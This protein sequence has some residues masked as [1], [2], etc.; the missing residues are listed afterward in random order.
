MVSL[1]RN[2][3]YRMEILAVPLIVLRFHNVTS[4]HAAVVVNCMLTETGLHVN[5]GCSNACIT[6]K[7]L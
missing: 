3:S 7:W 4:H 6:P 1:E 5:H 2:M